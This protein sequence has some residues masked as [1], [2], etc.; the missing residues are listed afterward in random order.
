MTGRLG[1]GVT[2]AEG[3]DGALWRV[4]RVEGDLRDVR[5]VSAATGCLEGVEVRFLATLSC[6]L[7]AP[8]V[9]LA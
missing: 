3:L 4:V 8:R 6:A 5:R 2:V 1:V 9:A 7:R